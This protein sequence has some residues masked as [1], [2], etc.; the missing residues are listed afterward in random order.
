M[1]TADRLAQYRAKR[2]FA[3][4]PEPEG[5]L[6]AAGYTLAFVIQK[7]AATR[8]HYDFRLE[9]DGVMLSWAVPKGPSFDPTDKR[10]AIRTED[11]PASY[12]TFEGTIPKG[13]YGAGT[14]IVWDQGTWEPVGD[15]R[16]GLAAGKLLFKLH[17][18]KM[19]GLWELVNIGKG[20]EK[21]VPWILF[22]KRDGHAR[23]KAADY[24][25]VT[26]LPDSVL[27]QPL[28]LPE[29]V[30]ASDTQGGAVKAALP[31]KLPPQ[32][33]TL[34]T[35]VPAA[36][37]WVY[38]IKFDGYR[39]MARIEDGEPRLIT[40]GGHDWSVKMPGLVDELASLGLGSAWLDGEIV[41]LGDDGSPSFNALQNSFDRSRTDDIVYFLFDAPFFEGHD[42]RQV[43]LHERRALLKALFEQKQPVRLRFSEAFEAD[44]AS[45]LQSACGMQL[46]GPD[47]QT[48][49]RTV[50]LRP[51]RD[52][53]QAQMQAAPGIHRR[54]F[55]RPG[56]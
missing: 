20:A 39:L 27:R 25:V 21:Q 45:I 55:H 30:T 26:A 3:H 52:L 15:P 46:E 12:N 24:D 56:G 35:G 49:G 22:K 42:L 28:D 44:P 9:L 19:A 31:A 32:L 8:L 16:Q 17:G 10:M 14:V 48:R 1:G 29:K 41:V 5:K 50:R 53:A 36:G 23:P 51:H 18:Q 13:H 40:R 4:T 54:R 33:A 47:R 2:K 7:H 38:E 43:P 37:D 11:H 34:A 6:A